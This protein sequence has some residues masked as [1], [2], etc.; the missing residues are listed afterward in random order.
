MSM[1]TCTNCGKNV[2]SSEKVCP[3]C[4]ERLPSQTTAILIAVLIIA[5]VI[6]LMF[7][8][9]ALY[10]PEAFSFPMNTVLLRWLSIISIGLVFQCFF[11]LGTRSINQ[12]KGYEGGFAWGFFLGIIGI[13]IVACKENNQTK[14]KQHGESSA[15][16]SSS[17]A[18]DSKAG[19][20]ERLGKLHNDGILTDA[21]FAEAKKKLISKM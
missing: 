2:S 13:V 17:I 14:T 12:S 4:G 5:G 9:G 16:T 10:G 21:E 20:L 11:G 3:N 7:L 15:T 18:F 1:I 19:E 6:G 8:F